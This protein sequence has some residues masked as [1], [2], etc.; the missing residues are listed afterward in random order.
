MP[1]CQRGALPEWQIESPPTEAAASAIVLQAQLVTLLAHD[2]SWRAQATYT[3]RNR[4]RQFFAVR[5]PVGALL[6]SVLVR[7][8]PSRAI[9]HEIDGRPAHLI[10]LPEAS[11]TDLSY[12]ITLTCHGQLPESLPS[13]VR[14]NAAEVEIPALQVVSPKESAEFGLS[15][16]STSWEVYLPDDLKAEPIADAERTNMNSSNQTA[17]GAAKQLSMLNDLN[18]MLRLAGSMQTV[19]SA[20]DD[21]RLSQSVGTGIGDWTAVFGIWTCHRF[22]ECTTHQDGEAATA[23]G[24]ARPRR[25]RESGDHAV[26]QFQFTGC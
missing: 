6:S 12:D 18:E 13:G 15:V 8:Q 10:A 23:V 1:L 24:C 9:S 25:R 5:L 20:E 22:E 14:F 3:V 21:R 26:R 17:I 16:L 2:G 11:V 19:S 7:D 4:G